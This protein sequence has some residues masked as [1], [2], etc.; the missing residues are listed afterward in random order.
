MAQAQIIQLK[1]ARSSM[2]KTGNFRIIPIKKTAQAAL[3]IGPLQ[4]KVTRI[5]KIVL[6]LLALGIASCIVLVSKSPTIDASSRA[7]RISIQEI[8]ALVH[9]E[10]LP[11]QQFEDQ[12]LIYLAPAQQTK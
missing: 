8:H 2:S 7:Q 12:S 11:V 5:H 1:I 10:D 3:P 4:L 9:P 6:P